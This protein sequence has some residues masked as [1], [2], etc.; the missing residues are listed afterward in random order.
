MINSPS[1]RE[2]IKVCIRVR[3]L[4]PHEDVEYWT[5]DENE[6]TISSVN[7]SDNSNQ[8][9]QNSFMAKAL[10]DS[11]YTSQSFHFDKIYPQNSSSQTIYKEMCRDITKN[12]INGI[13]G[14]IFTYGQTTSGKTFTMLGNPQ[15]PGILPCVLKDLF[16]L[17][18]KETCNISVYCSYI[19]IYNENIHDLLSNTNSLKLID[20]PKYGVIVSGAKL[21]HI[22]NF[23]GGIELKD[24][25][26]ENRKY[27]DTLINEYS[28]RSHTIFQIFLESSQMDPNTNSITSRN[29]V[30][31]MIDLAGSEKLNE[32]ESN[33]GETGY[34]NKSL[35]ALANVINK[36]AEGK[37]KHIPYRDSKL[38]RLLSMALGGNSYI[39]V[40]CNVSPSATNFYQTLSTLRFASRAKVVKLNPNINEYYNEREMIEMY[41]KEIEKLQ[42]EINNE[43]PEISKGQITQQNEINK[44]EEEE[45]DYKMKYFNEVLKNKRLKLENDNLKKEIDNA[46][47]YYSNVNNTKNNSNNI[48]NTSNK[49]ENSFLHPYLSQLDSMI[50]SFPPHLQEIK[51]FFLS[52]LSQINN[53]YLNQL[54][55]LQQFY[56]NKVKENY[57]KI[58]SYLNS[59]Q[60]KNFINNNNIN[61]TTNNYTD[62]DFLNNIK[63]KNLFTNISLTFDSNQTIQSIK[64]EYEKKSDQIEQNM[65]FYKTTIDEIFNKFI[66]DLHTKENVNNNK[67]LNQKITEEYN[68]CNL[69]LDETYN[70]KQNELEKNFFETLRIISSIKKE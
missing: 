55:T 4:L 43:I 38:T 17:I 56:L 15:K 61:S 26:E 69:L 49:S 7:F 36:L 70:E 8:I 40:I 63:S 3:P 12:V 52:S 5:I 14:S 33:S 48:S 64:G 27:R 54:D 46:F 58:S 50:Q 31:N 47:I 23:E 68:I 25:G 18:Q 45:K 35:F 22:K 65:S 6:N 57:S 19:E 32:T 44:E 34:I 9:Q 41:K 53:E 42:Y 67:V 51:Q 29:S 62:E 39:T 20:D 59:P 24:K 66:N 2:T 21:V 37:K 1:K 13:N 60:Q 10:M 30:L 11:I 28:S 16:D